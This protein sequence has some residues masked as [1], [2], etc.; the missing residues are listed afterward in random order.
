[1]HRTKVSY[2][3]RHQSLLHNPLDPF[4]RPKEHDHLPIEWGTF[5]SD[6]K[7]IDR[8]RSVKRSLNFV[9]YAQLDRC[10]MGVALSSLSITSHWK[11]RPDLGMFP[12]L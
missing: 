3:P 11:L 5:T 1:V 2:E 9:S 12:S 6:L 10:P 4:I 8:C 7:P